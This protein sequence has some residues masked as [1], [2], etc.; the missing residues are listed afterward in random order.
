MVRLL[1]QRTEFHIAAFRVDRV[2]GVLGAIGRPGKRV[3][4][5]TITELARV[6]V[7]R[8]SVE[9]SPKSTAPPSISGTAAV[10][11]TPRA[12]PGR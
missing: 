7:A 3:P 11:Q 9:L 2:L 12:E 1:E 6:M 10:G 4:M 5:A 8:M